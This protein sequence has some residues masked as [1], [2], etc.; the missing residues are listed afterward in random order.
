[1][2]RKFFD[3]VQGSHLHAPRNAKQI[4]LQ[5]LQSHE[6]YLKGLNAR[7]GIA[8]GLRHRRSF[9]GNFANLAGLNCQSFIHT[10]S[11]T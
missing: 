10:H 11:C 8:A 9:G 1:M 3:G 4:H 2:A 6:E 7:H 5:R